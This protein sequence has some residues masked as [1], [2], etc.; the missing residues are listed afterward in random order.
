[1]MEYHLYSR[2]INLISFINSDISF[3]YYC[4]LRSGAYA[5]VERDRIH[6]LEAASSPAVHRLDCQASLS[7][8]AGLHCWHY[9]RPCKR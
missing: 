2:S 5:Q 4:D 3:L 1:M 9:S 8:E 6:S 7:S